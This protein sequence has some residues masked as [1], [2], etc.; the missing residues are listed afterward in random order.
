[1]TEGPG[2]GC[3]GRSVTEM[4]W[5]CLMKGWCCLI[6]G[7]CCLM[8]GWCCLIKGWCCLMRRDLRK[9]HRPM[10]ASTVINEYSACESLGV[11]SCTVPGA[12]PFDHTVLHFTT[13]CLPGVGRGWGGGRKAHPQDPEFP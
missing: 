6:K 1:M 5:C 13:K 7:W 4:G 3:D 9:L 10:I 2:T 12:T 8:K 11:D